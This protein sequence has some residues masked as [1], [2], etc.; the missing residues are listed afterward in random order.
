MCFNFQ[1]KKIKLIWGK[2]LPSKYERAEQSSELIWMECLS[3]VELHQT[4]Q[5]KRSS[6]E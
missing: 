2:K 6:R 4:H 1:I 3:W 5:A